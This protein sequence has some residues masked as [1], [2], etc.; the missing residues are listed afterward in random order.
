MNESPL[1]LWQDAEGMALLTTIADSYGLCPAEVSA[2]D[3][4][5][6]YAGTE[7]YSGD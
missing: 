1:E 5:D 6:Y 2:R 3:I 4:A 7:V